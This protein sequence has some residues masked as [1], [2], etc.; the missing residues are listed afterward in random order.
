[1][2]KVLVTGGAGF[3]GSSLALGL[4][5]DRPDVQVVALDNL[6]RRGAELNLGRLRAGGVQFIHGDVRN[7]EDLE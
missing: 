7:P 2:D 1:M 4:R 6:K 3:V 5:H